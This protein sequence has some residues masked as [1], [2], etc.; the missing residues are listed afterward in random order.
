M[1]RDE[2]I[3][4]LLEKPVVLGIAYGFDKLTDLHN[5]WIK[6]MVFGEE[7]ETLMAHRGSFK[8]T[9]VSIALAV[10][11]VWFPH[12]KTMFMRKTDDDTK[13][14]VAQAKKILESA[15]MQTIVYA[16]YGVPLILVKDSALEIDTNLAAGDPRGTPQL[17]AI[18]IGSSL[19]GKHFDNIF[20]DDIV[21]VKD[22]VSKAERDRTKL[23]Y[24]ELQNIKN[25]G[26]KIFNTGTPWHKDDCFSIMPKAKVFDCYSTGLISE[27][28]IAAIKSAMAPSL[29]AANYEMRHIASDDVMFTDPKTGA[30][31]QYIENGTAHVDAAYGGSDY[32]AFTAMNRVGDAVYVYGR[33]W[34]K[35]VDDVL[36]EIAECCEHFMLGKIFCEDN[37]DKGYLAKEMKRKYNLRAVSYHENMNKFLKITT[38]LKTLWSDIVFIEGTD[39]EYIEQICDYTED[40]E[41]DDAPDSCAC[42]ARRFVKKSGNQSGNQGG[43]RYQSIF[44]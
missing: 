21:N 42:L 35:H 27:E 26:G 8:T 36:P 32:T 29:F 1:T 4:I 31:T 9:C 14:I 18:G 11:V 40:A 44:G 37:G 28:E 41:H 25:R 20:T 16:I 13:E 3:Y 33:L 43:E 34:H 30:E 10:I 2:A 17:Y 5:E 7:D 38:Y 6:A 12:K 24:Q 39:K 15:V 22:R 23:M 19:T